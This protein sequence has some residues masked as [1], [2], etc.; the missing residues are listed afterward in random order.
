MREEHLDTETTIVMSDPTGVV[1]CYLTIAG[2]I[3]SEPR[4]G[5][6]EYRD[7]WLQGLLKWFDTRCGGRLNGFSVP[8]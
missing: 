7:T 5:F 3:P 1:C 2:V 6:P 8:K 4:G